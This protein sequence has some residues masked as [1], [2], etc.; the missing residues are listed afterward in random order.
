MT[1]EQ[2]DEEL[3]KI[4]IRGGDEAFREL[5]ERYKNYV[6]SL[7]FR[8]VGHQETAE[9]LAQE[10]FIKVY[11]SLPGFRGDAKFST[12]LYRLTMNL[13][14]DYRRSQQRRPYLVLLDKMKDWLVDW[15]ETPEDHAL[16]NEER[17]EVG[18]LL[19][20]L[21][22]KYRMVMYLYHYRQL[23]YQEISE[24]L[25]LPL[26]TVETRLYRGKALLK[27]RWMEVNGGESNAQKQPEG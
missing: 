23:S 2:T 19:D 16:K 5:I 9:D 22:D 8:M 1:I 25:N 11:R 10:A 13:V 4:V 17:Q 21:S 6:Y 24:I 3:V 26:K 12:W 18:Q 7:I 14:K 20:S 27:E 15:K